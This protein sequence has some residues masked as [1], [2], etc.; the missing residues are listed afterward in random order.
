MSGCA[1]RWTGAR[2]RYAGADA[3]ALEGIDLR[4]GAGE[5][6]LLTGPTGCGKTTL[7]KTAN[8]LIPRE[9]AGRMEG[10]VEVFG[11]NGGGSLPGRVGLLFQNPE[12]QILCARVEDEVAFGP[13]N[14]GVPSGEIPVRIAEALAAVSA[15]EKRRARCAELSGGEKQR[16]ALASV[17]S[18]HPRLLALDEPT[19]QLDERGAAEVLRALSQIRQK[20]GIA[21]LVAEHR[22]ERV[23]PLADRLVVMEGGRIR[24]AFSRENFTEALPLLRELGLE[25]PPWMELAACA[26]AGPAGGEEA[27]CARLKAAGLRIQKIPAENHREKGPPL[28]RVRDLSHRYRGAA[29]PALDAVSLLLEAGEILALLGHNGA[30]KSTFLSLLA[31][32]L[33]CQSGAIAWFGEPAGRLKPHTLAGRV[34]FLFQNPDLMLSAETVEDEV[35]LGPRLL[36]FEAG[37]ARQAVAAGLEGLGIAGLRARNP[38]SLSRG[39]RLRVALTALLAGEPRVLLL[40]EPTAGLD[41]GSRLSFL[42][43]LRGWVDAARKTRAVILCTH[44]S[45]A[46]LRVA[47]R[48]MLLREGKR[49]ALGPIDALMGGE[50]ERII[51]DEEVG[52]LARIARRL[53]APRAP[54]T[55]EALIGGLARAE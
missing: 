52:P 19:S 7:L 3:P 38:F 34:G 22:I 27:A 43:D 46:A 17:L 4:I 21:F 39:E 31:G 12:D 24:G 5:F 41:R 1:I 28:L 15:E 9:S 45:D 10:S 30:G 36:G 13:E 48:A 50:G 8:G 55:I 14:M 47:D 53:A 20:L 33:P 51:A 32:L 23:L 54:R 16:I 25:V 49:A 37:R 40:D 42:D 11:E 2:F 29:A 44:D 35:A 6:V 26:E 18:L